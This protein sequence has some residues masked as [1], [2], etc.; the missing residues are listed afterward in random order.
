MVDDN[1]MLTA[2]H[3]VTD[4]SG[5]AFVP[6]G[7]L[8][9]TRGNAQAGTTCHTVDQVTVSPR[10]RGRGAVHDYAVLRLS[11][12][13]GVGAMLISQ[14]SNSTIVAAN[15]FHTGYPGSLFGC[16]AN[17]PTPVLTVSGASDGIYSTGDVYSAAGRKIRTR[18]DTGAGESGGPFFYYPSGCCSSEFLTG[19]LSGYTRSAVPHTGGP[20]GSTIR[21]WVIANTP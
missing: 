8:A 16:A 6:S 9:C 12:P 7:F 5:N 21:S 3:C 18:I 19:V 10:W 14:A 15:G 4:G 2:A 11:R 20:K 17:N 1:W 13:P